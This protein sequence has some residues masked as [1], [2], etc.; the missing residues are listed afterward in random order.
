M[1]SLPIGRVDTGFLCE[2]QYL[3]RRYGQRRNGLLGRVVTFPTTGRFQVD[4]D[5]CQSELVYTGFLHLVR[6]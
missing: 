2:E 3:P 5:G 4:A 1:L 6:C